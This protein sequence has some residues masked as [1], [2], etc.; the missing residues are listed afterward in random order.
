MSD[1]WWSASKLITS[2][3]LWHLA[4]SLLNTYIVM[5]TFVSRVGRVLAQNKENFPITFIIKEERQRN[6]LRNW[7]SSW[8]G[9]NTQ[10]WVDFWKAVFKLELNRSFSAVVECKPES[11]RDSSQSLA[12]RK[13]LTMDNIVCMPVNTGKSTQKQILI[14]FSL[15]LSFHSLLSFFSSLG[16]NCDHIM[17]LI[18]MVGSDYSLHDHNNHCIAFWQISHLCTAVICQSWPL[19]WP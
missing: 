13:I 6:S 14:G 16:M 12:L 8:M 2:F 9:Q 3:I 5:S 4:K 7:P 11:K 1:I 19:W 10:F 18:E 17:Q 15:P